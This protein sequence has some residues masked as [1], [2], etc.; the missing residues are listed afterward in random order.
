MLDMVMHSMKL[1]FA[2]KLFRDNWAFF[3][4]LGLGFLVALVLMVGI[5]WVN[6]W[7]GMVAGGAIGGALMPWL[8]RDLK[9]N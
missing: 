6:L 4:Q 1:F 3:R 9:Y 7:L 5:G 8:F 2:G